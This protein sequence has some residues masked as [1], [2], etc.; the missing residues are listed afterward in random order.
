MTFISDVASSKF[1]ESPSSSSVIGALSCIRQLV[2]QLARP[3]K[4]DQAIEDSFGARTDDV[5]VN[6]P[7]PSL[8]PI[9]SR[10]IHQV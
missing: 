5:G 4:E 9:I 3:A 7:M 6:D 1:G 8:S 10:Q 2:P